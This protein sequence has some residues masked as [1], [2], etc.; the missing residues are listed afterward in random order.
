MSID[1]YS[2][3]G[4]YDGDGDEIPPIIK[5]SPTGGFVYH[6]DVKH[7]INKEDILNAILLSD[8]SIPL[9]YQLNKK[10]D[11][12]VLTVENYCKWYEL[13]LIG[14]D[15]SIKKIEFDEL[16]EYAPENQSAYCDHVPNPH[17]VTKYAVKLGYHLD[18]QSYEMI[19]GRW[20]I[21]YKGNF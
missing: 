1:R 5:I 13:Y 12:P 10:I 8:R 17:A 21:E 7:L 18:E 16:Q 19:V 20:M 3:S 2:V 14:V 6:R 15:G 9:V 4:R 11:Q